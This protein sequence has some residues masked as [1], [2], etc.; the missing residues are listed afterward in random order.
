MR[1]PRPLWDLDSFADLKLEDE[2][3][4]EERFDDLLLKVDLAVER[5]L[6][7]SLV[8]EC[9]RLILHLAGI[10]QKMELKII[11]ERSAN[12]KIHYNALEKCFAL[13]KFY[14]H[15]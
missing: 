10:W 14:L 3:E 6:K 11:L 13:I 12:E 1:L 7:L 8:L 15:S 5:F 9:T 2:A 4:S